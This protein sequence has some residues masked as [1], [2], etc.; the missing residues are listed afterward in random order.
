MY[1]L[2]HLT[3]VIRYLY[4]CAIYV[5]A[6]NVEHTWV[7]TW[8]ARTFVSDFKQIWSFSI[9]FRENTHYKISRISFLL[10]LHMWLPTMLSTLGSS[11]QVPEIFRP[12]LKQIWSFLVDFRENIHFKISRIFVLL[13]LRWSLR[14]DWQTDVA[15]LIV[16]FS[17]CTNLTRMIRL[18]LT[19]ELTC[20]CAE[21]EW[22]RSWRLRW[23]RTRKE[24]LWSGDKE[25]ATWWR[26][27]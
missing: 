25:E 11:R 2:C 22:D 23:S 20:L 4:C 27:W 7:L 5:V 10:E 21:W 24:R 8:S 16:D 12:V 18:I 6:N 14:T 17:H 3:A 15:K 26:W 19:F 1:K 13:E 9:D